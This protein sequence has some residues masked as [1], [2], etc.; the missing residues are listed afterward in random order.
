MKKVNVSPSLENFSE[1]EINANA[2]NSIKGGGVITD[3]KD[4]KDPPPGC[5]TCRSGFPGDTCPAC[6]SGFPG[7]GIGDL[8][9]EFAV[10]LLG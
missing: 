7:G 3:P 8:V 9:D 5:P 10:D 6:R 4:E 2:V 1:K